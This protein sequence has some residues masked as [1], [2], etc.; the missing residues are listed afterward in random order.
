MRIEIPTYTEKKE[1]FQYLRDNKKTLIKSKKSMPIESDVLGFKASFLKPENVIKEYGEIDQDSVIVEV[2]ANLANW[3]DSHDDV[4]LE[5]NWDKSINDKGNLIAHLKDHIHSVSAKVGKTLK[6]ESRMIDLA[7]IGITSDVKKSQALVM[8]S[9]VKKAY[10]E[11]VFQLYKDGE[12]NQ[13]SVGMQ[14]VNLML[15]INDEDFEDEY[16]VW[17]NYYSKIINKER[18]NDTGYFWAVLESKIF[19]NS[20]VLWGSNSATPTIS[21]EQS[22][23]EPSNDTRKQS[24]KSTDESKL[25]LTKLMY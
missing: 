21:M 13:H 25:F 19:E 4:M 22:K 3:M 5:G 23:N 17:Q 6:V 18:A 8:R 12:I 11:K 9:E 2:I 1:L 14:Y 15:A 20:A 10:D 16:K 7:S 24:H